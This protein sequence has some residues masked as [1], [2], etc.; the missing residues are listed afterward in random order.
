MAYRWLGVLLVTAACGVGCAA[1]EPGDPFCLGN[2][3]GG[4]DGGGGEGGVAGVGT[5][6][7]GGGAGGTGG[8]VPACETSPLCQSCPTEGFC[9]ANVDCDVG[10]VCIESGCTLD[11][12][13]IKRCVFA[14][15]GAC[16]TTDDCPPEREC[17]E[18]PLE[19]KRCIKTTPGCSTRFDC[20]AGFACENGSCVDRRVPCDV[21]GDCPKNHVCGN[22]GASEFCVRIHQGCAEEFDCVGLAPHCADV[23]GDGNSECAGV[24]DPNAPTL[25]TCTNASCGDP[26]APV[27]EAGMVGSTS[28]CGRYGLCL[29]DDDCVSGD[30]CAALWPDG[31][32]ECVPSGG[33]CT[34]FTDCPIQQVCAV[35]REGGPP[36]CQA[37]YQP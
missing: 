34:T 32:K 2:G 8:S 27:C 18:V 7:T 13:A 30:I 19:G 16:N 31:R 1:D 10:S 6:G 20:V 36:A 15:G 22:S 25:E 11:G 4:S 28:E 17:V 37:G 12:A 29:S 26:S 24:F 23:D 3:C 35:P 14:G 33:D 5:G 9:D 21:D